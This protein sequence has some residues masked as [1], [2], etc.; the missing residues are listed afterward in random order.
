VPGAKLPAAPAP[1]PYLPDNPPVFGASTPFS[2]LGTSALT[3]VAIL[4]ML[5]ALLASARARLSSAATIESGTFV[6]RM[7]RPG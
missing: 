3:W 1:F 2:G 4:T 6:S 7:E 5:M